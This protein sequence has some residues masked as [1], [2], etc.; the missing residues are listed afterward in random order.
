MASC[1]PD[2]P[3]LLS[4]IGAHTEIAASGLDLAAACELVCR[5]ARVLT[6]AEAAIL[7]LH[8]PAVDA[9]AGFLA[10]GDV[11][12]RV[13]VG[14]VDGRRAAGTLEAVAHW[15]GAF[16]AT[17]Y[18]TLVLLAGVAGAELARA[19]AFERGL[20]AAGT[21]P[22]TA[23]PNR[24]S[25]E[26]RLRHEVDR[27]ARYGRPL[28]LVI[29]AVD[30]LAETCERHGEHG[31]DDALLRVTHTLLSIRSSDEAFRIA[32]AEFAVLAPETDGEGVRTFG[33]R[34]RERIR[35]QRSGV[36]VAVTIGSAQAGD[37][38]DAGEA[39]ARALEAEARASLSSAARVPRIV[40][41]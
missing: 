20:Q 17:E 7:R 1:L 39:D 8:A 27:A 33:A 28:S 23:L 2:P 11:R 37:A 25:F 22:L 12:S 14:V 9:A 41:A 24:L 26:Y 31:G 16:D 35:A 3:A 36:P 19:R 30:G 40:A 15:P 21:D 18:E 32:A 6:G 29:V 34:L 10:P 4:I 5:R 38:G 13:S